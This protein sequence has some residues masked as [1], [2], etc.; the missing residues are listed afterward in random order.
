MW[1]AHLYKV[2]SIYSALF[3]AFKSDWRAI[4]I[5]FLLVFP[6][7]RSHQSCVHTYWYGFVYGFS[8]TITIP[9]TEMQSCLVFRYICISYLI[10]HFPHIA[11][12]IIHLFIKCTYAFW[13][14]SSANMLMYNEYTVVVWLFTFSDLSVQNVINSSTSSVNN[15]RNSK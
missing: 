9:L 10:L 15:T 4:K 14:S 6:L 13:T 8:Q 2:G 12:S 5:A 11:C 1:F 3:Y 7:K